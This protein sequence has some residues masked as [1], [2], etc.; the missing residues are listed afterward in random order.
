MTSM[1]RKSA[2]INNHSKETDSVITNLP[3]KSSP[4]FDGFTDEFPK[5]LKEN[6]Y[7]CLSNNSKILKR[8]KHFPIYFTRPVLLRYQSQIMTLQKKKK[9]KKFI[10][11]YP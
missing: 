4:G 8:R 1:N 6:Q 3:T 10:S 2:Q 9:E 11:Q 7:Q 5:H